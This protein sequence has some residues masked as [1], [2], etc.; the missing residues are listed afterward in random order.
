MEL[1]GRSLRTKPPASSPRRNNPGLTSQTLSGPEY[2]RVVRSLRNWSDGTALVIAWILIASSAARGQQPN[3]PNVASVSSRAQNIE[4]PTKANTELPSKRYNLHINA[5][6]NTHDLGAIV[7]SLLVKNAP[8]QVGFTRDVSMSPDADGQVFTNDDGSRLAILIIKSSGAHALRAHF[9][10]FDLPPGD[11]VYIYGL[12]EDSTLSGPYSGKGPWGDKEFWSSVTEGDTIVIEHY[13]KGTAAK[14]RISGIAHLDYTKVEAF[15]PS[16]LSCE[17]DASCYSNDEKRAVARILFVNDSDGG[18]YVCTGTLVSDRYQDFIPYFLTANHCISSE[19][20][21]RSVVA[22]WFYQTTGCNSRALSNS[23]TT[24]QGANLLASN[25][26]KDYALLNGPPAPAGSVFSGWTSGSEGLNTNVHAFHHPGNTLP[27]NLDSYLRRADGYVSSTSALCSATG[28]QNGYAVNW[29]SGLTEPGSSGSGLWSVDGQGMNRLIGVLSCGPIPPSCSTRYNLYAKFSDIF[30]EIQPFIFPQNTLTITSANPTNDVAISVTPADD[31]GQNDGATPFSRKYSP[32]ASVTLTAPFSASGGTGFLKWQQDGV[33][34][35]TSSSVTVMMNTPHT[36]TAVYTSQPTI[37]VSVQ[38]SPSGRSFIVDG[39]G[40]SSPQVFSW[41]PGSNHT[42]ATNATQNG[43][44][45]TQFLWSGWSDGQGISHIVAPTDNATYTATFNTQYF[46]AMNAGTGGTVSPSSNWYSSGQNVP[47]SATASNGYSFST[48]AGSGNGS[49]SGTSSSTSVTMNGPINEM[50]NFAQTPIPIP[51]N[52]TQVSG[53]GTI[54]APGGGQAS[55]SFQV[56]LTRSNRGKVKV[57]GSFFYSDPA[58]SLNL[59][60]NK[61]VGLAMGGN[62]ATFGSTAKIG[63]G[64]RKQN[65]GF[66]VSV[67]DNGNPGTNDTFSISVN[68][69]YFASGNLTSGDIQIQ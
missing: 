56:G 30:A 53:S 8:N 62:V 59:S 35:V 65:I 3:I 13:A 32:T 42:I 29:I 52:P 61:I 2:G 63:S 48:W 27:P 69:G 50:S 14:L 28:L 7:P 67:T 66:S 36:M 54:N 39:N 4:R 55:F 43:D 41:M 23:W 22:Y 9:R 58:A 38:T 44:T 46:L 17:E 33:D 40:Y 10:D 51:T 6:R 20:E 16:T 37:Q 26:A 15:T 19:S 1:R 47:I 5:S 21:A 25:A 12:S 68:N 31:S 11:E 57:T 45:G 34:Y 24:T 18:S 64:R 49:Y 60:A